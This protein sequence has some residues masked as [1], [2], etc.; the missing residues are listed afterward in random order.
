MCIR[1]SR[2]LV[3]ARTP[4]RGRSGSGRAL[5][6]ELVRHPLSGEDELSSLVATIEH[7]RKGLPV[8][9]RHYLKLNACLLSFNVDHDF[10]SV[11]DGLILVDLTKTEPRVL[12]RYMGQEGARIYFEYHGIRPVM[13]A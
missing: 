1:D 4:F 11:V 7:D 3:Q 10:S 8:L 6:H 5:R 2:S 13:S 12:A 9:L